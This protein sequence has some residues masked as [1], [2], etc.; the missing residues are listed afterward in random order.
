M[1]DVTAGEWIQS[2]ECIFSIKEPWRMTAP[3]RSRENGEEL[4]Q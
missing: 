2:M 1:V 3:T 4:S